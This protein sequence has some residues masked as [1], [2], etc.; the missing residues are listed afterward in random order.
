MRRISIQRFFK[1]SHGIFVQ[2]LDNDRLEEFAGSLLSRSPSTEISWSVYK[3]YA[4]KLTGSVYRIL[5]ASSQNIAPRRQNSLVRY[6]WCQPSLANDFVWNDSCWTSCAC[7]RNVRGS[8]NGDDAGQAH[9]RIH[10][11]FVLACAV[12]MTF[13]ETSEGTFGKMFCAV[14][15]GPSNRF[16][17]PEHFS[18]KQIIEW[19][20]EI[21]RS[22]IWPCKFRPFSRN[23]WSQL[24]AMKIV[25][26]C[27]AK[28]MYL[29]RKEA[30]DHFQIGQCKPTNC[31]QFR[32]GGF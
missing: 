25:L 30:S 14:L 32:C 29:P 9:L 21:W 17:F 22:K 12:N 11:R 23:S 13:P 4:R 15:P 20:I 8:E 6:L 24:L 1:R 27:P 5:D 19:F 2:D 18:I 31:C 7:P 3:D 28:K 10:P 16:Q 26:E